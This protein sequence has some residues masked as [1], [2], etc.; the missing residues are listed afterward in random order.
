MNLFKKEFNA[1]EAAGT[2]STIID[3]VIRLFRWVYKWSRAQGLYKTLD[4][5][6]P[7][8]T[9]LEIST[10]E[11]RLFVMSLFEYISNDTTGLSTQY[12]VGLISTAPIRS[13]CGKKGTLNT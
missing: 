5:M 9:E 7:Y 4:P 2:A 8:Q 3:T 11:I 10:P 12:K 13:G 1:S 6:I